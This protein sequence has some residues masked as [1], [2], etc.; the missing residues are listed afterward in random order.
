[1]K[2]ALSQWHSL[3]A[4]ALQ[5]LRVRL[6]DWSPLQEELPEKGLRHLLVQPAHVDGGIW[7]GKGETMYF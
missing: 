1:M 7:Y 6:T 3:R 4:C 5:C 2:V